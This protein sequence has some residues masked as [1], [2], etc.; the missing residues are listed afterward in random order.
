MDF[1]GPDGGLIAT[2]FGTGCVACWGFVRMFMV[3]PLK[4][5]VAEL[6]DELT[7]LKEDCAKRDERQARRIDQL[8]TLLLMHGSGPLR[9]E[10]QKVVSEQ[11]VVGND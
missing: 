8:E 2:S 6:K 5:R 10:M 7:D 11:R 4:A 9:Q 3:P 1:L